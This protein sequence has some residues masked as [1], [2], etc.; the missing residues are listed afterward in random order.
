MDAIYNF[1]SRRTKNKSIFNGAAAITIILI[2]AAI[3]AEI[4]IAAL[5]S[6]YFSSQGQLGERI[7]YNASFAAQ[8]GI[9]DAILKIARN[10]NFNPSLIPPYQNPYTISV[11]GATAQITV[12]ISSVTVN[13]KCDTSAPAGTYEITSLGSVLNKNVKMRAL[14]YVNPSNG[15]INIQY[16]KEINV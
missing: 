11:N 9:D 6:S 1:Y 13:T 3:V 5:V 12:C 4:A 16:E 7:V 14:L 8:S 15:S 10:K 2:I